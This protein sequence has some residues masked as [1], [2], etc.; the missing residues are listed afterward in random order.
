MKNHTWEQ[1]NDFPFRG[2]SQKEPQRRVKGETGE[3]STNG[4]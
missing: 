1:H 3:E 4:I 2:M